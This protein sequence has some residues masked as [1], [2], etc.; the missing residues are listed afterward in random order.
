[1]RHLVCLLALAVM[2]GLFASSVAR[3]ACTE[4]LRRVP[5][6]KDTVVRLRSYACR[7]GE[8][9][10]APNITVE[11][12]RFSEQAASLIVAKRS[13]TLLVKTIGKPRVAENEVF[14]AYAE[15]LQQ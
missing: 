14:K 6:D 9:A 10:D 15:L 8:G 13:S 11:L 3:A 4:D 1:M 2:A 12:Y 5:L 7:A